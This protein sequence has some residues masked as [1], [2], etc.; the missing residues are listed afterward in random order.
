MKT[1]PPSIVQY[2]FH[3]VCRVEGWHGGV[4]G[5]TFWPHRE[6]F[7]FCQ[8]EGSHVSGH[9][10]RHRKSLR[11][12]QEMEEDEE[13]R[14]KHHLFLLCCLRM[15]SSSFSRSFLQRR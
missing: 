14:Q 11:G 8:Q 1:G 13:G 12:A 5:E 7:I 4:T 9:H 6:A 15:S 10:R 3:L 2:S